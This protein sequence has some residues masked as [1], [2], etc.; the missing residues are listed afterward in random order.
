MIEYT[1]TSVLLEESIDLLNPQEGESLLD[2]TLGL[3]GHASA[4]IKKIGPSG[5]FIGVDADS[6]NLQEAQSRISGSADC[7]FHHSNFLHLPDLNLPKVDIIFADLG[8]SSPH[9]DDPERGFTF[10]ADAPLDLRYDQ[11]SG[12]SAAKWI[13]HSSEEEIAQVLKEYAEVPPYKL[14]ALIHQSDIQT[15]TDLVACIEQIFDFK[16]KSYMAQIFQAF[17][18]V[19]NH[20]LEAL[21]V[22]LEYGPEFLNPGGR[23]GIMTYHSLED[24][25]VKQAFKALSTAEI[26][27]NTGQDLA[28]APFALINKKP[29]VPLD[30]EIESNPRSRSA[31]LRGLR[32][33]SSHS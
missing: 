23:I 14:A 16:A 26:D 7:T 4:F 6:R 1:H 25:R 10:R 32:R 8:L 30:A 9:L 18:I 15:T 3:A 28:P 29:I 5:S 2:V 31:K 19:V 22:L 33:V 11:S 12:V 13:K 20:E 17:R 21:D 27:E 24:R